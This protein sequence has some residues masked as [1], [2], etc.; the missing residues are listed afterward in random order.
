MKQNFV[1]I[2]IQREMFLVYIRI[3]FSKNISLDIEYF[4]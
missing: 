4:C 3:F 1:K 2:Q